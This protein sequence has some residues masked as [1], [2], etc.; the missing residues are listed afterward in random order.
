MSVIHNT[1]RTEFT[2]RK[3]IN[4]ICYHEM[5]ESVAMG[6]SLSTHIPTNDDPSDLIMKVITIQKRQNHVGNI[7]YNIY[8][9]HHYG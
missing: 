1:Q 4:S 8:D 3:N 5:G 2:P 6:E 7:L 9:E